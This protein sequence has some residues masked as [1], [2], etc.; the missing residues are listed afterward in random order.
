MMSGILAG[1]DDPVFMAQFT[2]RRALVE[3]L[4]DRWGCDRSAARD[5]LDS[6]DAAAME[7]FAVGN[8]VPRQILH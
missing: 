7:L 2:E 6:E 5:W 3:T 8:T 4:A 1:L